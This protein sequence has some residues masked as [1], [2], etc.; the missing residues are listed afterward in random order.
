MQAD[1]KELV[2]DDRVKT[3]KHFSG[4]YYWANLRKNP[5]WTKICEP[6]PSLMKTYPHLIRH[7]TPDISH[8]YRPHLRQSAYLYEI[9]KKKKFSKAVLDFWCK[10]E[11]KTTARKGSGHQEISEQKRIYTF[12]FTLLIDPT[13]ASHSIFGCHFHIIHVKIEH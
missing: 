11:A 10:T 7:P 8:V 1:N 4:K 6:M 5:K 13:I 2:H 12:P 9:K 3:T